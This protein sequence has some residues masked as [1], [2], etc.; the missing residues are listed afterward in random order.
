MIEGGWAVKGDKGGETAAFLCSQNSTT[1][2]LP[3]DLGKTPPEFEL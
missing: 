1:S 3:L 2:H